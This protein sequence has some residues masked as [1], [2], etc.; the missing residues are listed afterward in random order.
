MKKTIQEESNMKREVMAEK[1][2]T[3]LDYLKEEEKKKYRAC[4]IDGKIRELT[5][6]FSLDKREEI[7]Y[8]D[9]CDSEATRIYSNSIRFLLSIAAKRVNPKI[10]IRFFYNIS[11]SLFAK[12]ISPSSF[13]VT[14]KFVQALD[15]ERKHLIS[16]DVPFIRQ[17][18]TQPSALETYR[19]EKKMD[20]IQIRKY[21]SEDYV[22]ICQTT[23]E[24]TT[25]SD[26]LYGYL[27]P[28][29]GYLSKF[30][31]QI[32]QPGILIRVPRA[33]CNGELPPFSDESRFATSLAS[34][35]AWSSKN[36]LDT[37]YKVN[38]FI[39]DYGSR[40]LIN[41]SEARINN[42]L[43][44]LGSR[45]VGREEKIRLICIAG[46]SSSGK[47]S[48]SN[49]LQFE[50]MA[51][52]L[53]PVRISR[54]NFYIPRGELKPGTDIES[55]DALDL[56]FFNSVRNKLI[57]GEEVTLPVYDFKEGKRKDGKK[58]SVGPNQPIIIEGIHALNPLSTASI[59][60]FQKFRI[61]IAPQPQV[62]IDNHTPLS[63]SDLR[64][65]RRIARDSR[66]RGSSALETIKRWPNVRQG[67]FKYIYP[68]QQNADFVFDSY[69][70]YEPAALRN[71]VIP[72]LEKVPAD[73]LEHLTAS[74]LKAR[75]KYFIP[76]NLDDIPCNSLRR[77]FVGGT[78]FK[79]A[80]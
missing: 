27:V 5:Y 24:G 12:V 31:L 18:V 3:P 19:Q 35:Y 79:D 38:K 33:E 7:T 11:R 61:Y 46:P 30:A 16:L 10:E 4:I 15:K 44:E 40:E 17:K 62:N 36:N 2:K 52:T 37:V 49:R 51:K 69:R 70:P 72:E 39:K 65:L 20:K 6:V 23:I 76:I 80:R 13:R 58:I 53:R 26:Y 28:S 9:L 42:R 21:R 68:S 77:E 75:V 8:L 50:L 1:G 74:R 59:P 43:A 32:Y 48:F 78:S 64:L 47:T 14:M 66:T 73:C 55:I 54:D 22:H 71:L 45:I 34:S 60:E 29:S 25:Y 63:R 67:E 57:Q 56:P 41:L